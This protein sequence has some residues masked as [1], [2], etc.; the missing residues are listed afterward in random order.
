M[1]EPFRKT[2]KKGCKEKA[3]KRSIGISNFMRSI[4]KTQPDTVLKKKGRERFSQKKVSFKREYH[5]K[6]GQ[7][8]GSGRRQKR[9]A[10][11]QIHPRAA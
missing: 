3:D 4:R 1:R 6:E 7:G 9:D 8:G 2:S 5:S 11:S 10:D